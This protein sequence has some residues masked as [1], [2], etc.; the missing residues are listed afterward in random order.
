V[1]PGNGQTC[2]RVIAER[3]GVNA[4]GLRCPLEISHAEN[5]HQKNRKGEAMSK[6]ELINALN[7]DLAAEWGTILRYTSQSSKLVGLHTIPLRDLLRAEIEDE[8]SHAIF[9]SEVI[10]DF[11]GEPTV[12]PKKFDRVADIKAML[13]QNISLEL[14]DVLNYT[15][16]SEM[17][18]EMGEIELKLRLE[19]MAADEAGHA[20]ELGRILRGI[21]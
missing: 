1:N 16:H 17:A 5:G 8:L 12:E 14:Q 4:R 18:G 7:E 19:E 9:L 21:T 3:S 6:E 13:E 11:G 2:E 15:K 10:V 20:R